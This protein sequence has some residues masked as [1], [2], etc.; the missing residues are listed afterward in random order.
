ME[1]QYDFRKRLL[2]IH[3][4]GIRDKAVKR[5]ANEYFFADTAVVAAEEGS[6]EVIKTAAS[7]FVDFLRTS[8][9]IDAR[10][11]RQEEAADVVVCL[12]QKHGIDMGTAGGYR[13][14]MT[15]VRDNGICVY[16]YDERGAAQGLYYLEDVMS[17]KKAP[18]IPYGIVK[19]RPAFSPQMVHSAYGLD[20]Y[21]DEYLSRIAH[22]GRDA[23][24]VFTKGV[25][26][27]PGGFLDFNELTARAAR[28][29]IDVYAYSYIKSRMSP[30]APEAEEYYE[31]SYGRLF[32]ECP[33]LKG[34]IL[35]GESVGFPSRDP[36]VAEGFDYET[37]VDGIPTGKPTAGWYPCCDY[38]IWLRLL[39]KVILKYNKTADIV[40]WT[41]NWGDKCEED[42]I[43]LIENLP[44]GISLL[45]T[46]EMFEPRSYGKSVGI[47]A[48]YT[49][50][51]EGAGRYFKSEAEAAKKR[52]IRLYS[53][54]NTGGLSW[55]FGVIPYEPMP[56]QWMRRYRA[57][58][59]ARDEW[60]LCGI[61]ESHHYGFF[62]SFISKLSKWCFWEPAENMDGI[63]NKILAAEFGEENAGEVSRALDLWSEAIRHYVPS[64]ADQYG[65]F[66]VGP[67]YPFCLERKTPV[68]SDSKAM[69]GNSICCPFYSD[70]LSDGQTVLS[71]RLPEEIKSL[72]VMR[73]L[74]EQGVSLLSEI[75]SANGKSASLL[76]LGKFILCSVVTGLNAKKWQLLKCRLYA[77]QDAGAIK[78]ILDEMETLLR[79]EIRNAASA[80]CHAEADSRLGWEPSMLY[81]ADK[82]HIEWKIRQVDYV[83]DYELP[84][85]RR[86]LINSEPTSL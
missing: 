53:M 76:H 74:T 61:M 73:R 23:I 60:G 65:A 2:T 18:A 13:G 58:F 40:F 7:D 12:A 9:G 36:H 49:L 56:Q 16:G 35:V 6:G 27:A 41:Y 10:P 46:F 5:G 11:A 81:M 39:K 79:A 85:Y 83:L 54:T 30:E 29:G 50:S 72:E 4:A 57:M 47:C 31:N 59:K 14:F 80:V 38:P 20:E 1:K 78:D 71:I 24:L 26:E 33:G 66:R 28:Y 52:G 43:K 86:S 48:D 3:E 84:K 34:V 64:N 75:P 19:K 45:A 67:S 82:R 8:M 42:R 70:G 55:D 32:R 21:P 51:F 22:E 77:E 25:N 17:F 63:L 44:E 69:F 68:P 62:P 37:T 15:E